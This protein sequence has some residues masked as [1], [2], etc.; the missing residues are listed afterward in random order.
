MKKQR[1]CLV[2]DFLKLFLL[3]TFLLYE[4]R[5]F[6][7]CFSKQKN[8]GIKGVFSFLFVFLVFEKKKKQFLKIVSKHGQRIYFIS[9]SFHVT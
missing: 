8:G 9:F 3:K 6:F 7:L 5:F 4:F 1:D 2:P